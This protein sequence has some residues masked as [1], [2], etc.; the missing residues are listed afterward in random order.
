MI[1]DDDLVGLLY[2]D[3]EIV[4]STAENV[5]LDLR[6]AEDMDDFAVPVVWGTDGWEQI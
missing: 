2:S 3:G 1:S 4:L 6:Y 5:W